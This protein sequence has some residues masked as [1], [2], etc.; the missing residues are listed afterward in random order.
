[1]ADP[2]FAMGGMDLKGGRGLPMQLCFIKFVCQNERIGSLRG[3]HAVC[4]H[5]KSTNDIVENLILIYFFEI[6]HLGITKF[7]FI[8]NISIVSVK[9]AIINVHCIFSKK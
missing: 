4:T 2:G 1:M 9:V 7:Y 6:N 5:P 8:F 3:A